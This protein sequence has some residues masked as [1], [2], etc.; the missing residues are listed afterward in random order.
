MDPEDRIDDYL[1]GLDDMAAEW[2]DLADI[3]KT[4]AAERGYTVTVEPDAINI[5][6]APSSTSHAA[7]TDIGR[8]VTTEVLIDLITFFHNTTNPEELMNIYSTDLFKY[9]AGDMIGQST[10][11]L[12]ISSVTLE[13]MNSGKGGEQTKPCLHFKEREKMMVLNKTNAAAI[14]KELGPETDRWIGG[15]VTLNAP[16]IEAFGRQSRSIRV[17]RIEPP[18]IDP[19]PRPANGAT[20]PQP[21]QLPID[22]GTAAQAGIDT[23]SGLF[24]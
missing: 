8:A 24:D 18:Q 13:K 9:L 11:T 10:I 19:K 21:A 17:T 7:V 14:A 5:E 15:R 1:T 4:V 2:S 3:L 22:D 6:S 23:A 20:Q 16:M 12:T